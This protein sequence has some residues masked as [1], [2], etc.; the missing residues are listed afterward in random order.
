MLDKKE[1]TRLY[2]TG[3][4]LRAVC[5]TIGISEGNKGK[6]SSILKKEGI[7]IRAGKEGVKIGD[8]V[9]EKCPDCRKIKIVKLRK[10]GQLPRRCNS[11]AVKKSH[12]DNPRIR[13]EESHYNWKGGININA[14]GYILE[15]V[16]PD[17]P[18][19][20]M[21]VNTGGRRFGGYI[22]QHRLVMAKHLGRI[23]EPYEIVHHK[24]GNKQ[25]NS[26]ENL[27]LT[28]RKKHKNT[29]WAGYKAGYEQG[30]FDGHMDK[31]YKKKSWDGKKWIGA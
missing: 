16:R 1:I 18:Y 28:E 23:L 12:K 5:R 24:D 3:L 2:K 8:Y 27:E 26:I 17:N 22:L 19:Y 30:Y 29:Y 6:I 9:E 31:T 4:S 21:A 13:R 20:E 14:Q 25:N 11:C 10:H 7:E 15:Y